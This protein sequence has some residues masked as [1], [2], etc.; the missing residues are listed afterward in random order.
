MSTKITY[1]SGEV[2][3]GHWNAEGRRHGTG[4]LTLPDSTVFCGK[5]QEGFFSGLGVLTLPD[6][7]R[8][9]GNFEK[10]LYNGLGVFVNAE[11]MKY[12][13]EFKVSVFYRGHFEVRLLVLCV[14]KPSGRVVGCSARRS[15]SAVPWRCVEYQPLH[16]SCTNGKHCVY[17]IVLCCDSV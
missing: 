12:E 17:W 14:Y 16:T 11:G 4:K 2:Y 8:Y 7:S 9:E 15:A 5:F 1:E 3:E 13:G 6:N 10:G